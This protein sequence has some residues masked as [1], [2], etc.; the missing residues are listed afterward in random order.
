M[1]VIFVLYALWF[2]ILKS[3]NDCKAF[4]LRNLIELAWHISHS[5]ETPS[6]SRARKMEDSKAIKK[7]IKTALI[8]ST[9][10]AQPIFV[11]VFAYANGFLVTRL[12]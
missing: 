2:I 4:H 1:N 10:T 11:F 9:F 12:N 3:P 7:R 8:S 5:N 6:T